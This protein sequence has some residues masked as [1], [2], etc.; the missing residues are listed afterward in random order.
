MDD[1][2]KDDKVGKACGKNE[3]YLEENLKERDCL[4]ERGVDERLISKRT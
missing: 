4:R 3:K 2:F 1:Q